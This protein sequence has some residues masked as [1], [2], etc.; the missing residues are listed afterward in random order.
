MKTFKY[1]LSDGKDIVIRVP[2]ELEAKRNEVF[3]LAALE[4]QDQIA[5]GK[6]GST[7]DI[8]AARAAAVNTESRQPQGPV[9]GKRRVAF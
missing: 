2:D 6:V 8:A 1:H 4:A 9:A 5:S 3:A 7:V